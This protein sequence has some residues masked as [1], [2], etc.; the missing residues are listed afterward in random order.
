MNTEMTDQEPKKSRTRGFLTTILY[1][2]LVAA[3]VV[4]LYA[5]LPVGSDDSYGSDISADGLSLWFT[6]DRPG[7][8]GDGFGGPGRQPHRREF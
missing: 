8:S 7:G 5:V 4:G 3:L 1:F 2:G 6:S